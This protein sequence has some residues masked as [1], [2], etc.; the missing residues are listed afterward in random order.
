MTRSTMETET[1]LER[2]ATL[3][4]HADA[5]AL[6]P[7][8]LRE[9][10]ASM[11]TGSA[12][13]REQSPQCV[14]GWLNALQALWSDPHAPLCQRAIEDL[15]I[16]TGWSRVLCEEAV[17]R[18]ANEMNGSA[19]L[20]TLSEYEM[21]SNRS[22]VFGSQVSAHLLG[23]PV[24]ATAAAVLARSLTL[25]SACFIKPA[26]AEPTFARHLVD[27]VHD[28][29]PMLASVVAQ[30][31]WPAGAPDHVH[32]L[33]DGSDVVGVSGDNTTLVNVRQQ[34]GATCA[35]VEY[36]ERVG[37]ALVDQQMIEDADDRSWALGCAEDAALYDQHGCL[38]CQVVYVVGAARQELWRAGKVLADEMERASKRW[39]VGRRAVAFDAGA[40][41][42]LHDLHV[43][44]AVGLAAHVWNAEHRGDWLVV[45][46]DD[47]SPELIPGCRTVMVKSLPTW[48]HAT[49]ALAGWT[50]RI[51]GVAIA[52]RDDQR[53]Q[54]AQAAEALGVG[55]CCQPGELQRPPVGW[56]QEGREPFDG[57]IDNSK[58]LD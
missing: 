37:V 22:V 52:A 4:G 48:D 54:I 8:S 40:A 33:G 17:A 39:P 49:E 46:V 56:H 21:H 11:R 7:H 3:A 18:A 42:W 50:G 13:L 55:Y 24:P 2:I 10:L 16:S 47:P 6:S 32:A 44:T 36:G 26:S 29:E 45:A 30:G 27:S 34:L 9:Q 19:W 20:R 53:A 57:W 15:G 58:S 25:R 12:W 35:L 38:S 5:T 14:A 43:R 41:S 1:R 51:Q 23:G 28:I 31:W